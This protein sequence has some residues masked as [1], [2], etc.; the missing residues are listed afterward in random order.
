MAKVQANVVKLMIP[1]VRLGPHTVEANAYLE[2]RRAYK[3]A[4][5]PYGKSQAGM[6]R[7]IQEQ[8]RGR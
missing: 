7:W 8:Q 4:G 6:A 3:A 5:C 1:A 2:L